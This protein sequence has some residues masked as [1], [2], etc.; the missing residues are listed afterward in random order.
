MRSVIARTPMLSVGLLIFL[1]AGREHT[2]IKIGLDGMESYTLGPF[3]GVL[4][5][6]DA[7]SMVKA[8]LLLTDS[9]GLRP[10][11]DDAVTI[12]R[13]TKRMGV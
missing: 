3:L 11:F 4:K 12:A 8:D 5:I 1:E 13:V 10:R 6:G 7:L 2:E 9:H